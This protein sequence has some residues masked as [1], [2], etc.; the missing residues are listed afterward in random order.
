MADTMSAGFPKGGVSKALRTILCPDLTDH[1]VEA[2]IVR[3]MSHLL[4]EDRLNG[5][6]YRSRLKY[7][8]PEAEPELASKAKDALWDNI[9][10]SG[11]QI[12]EVASPIVFPDQIDFNRLGL[13][14]NRLL[15]HEQAG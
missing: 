4:V 7:R 15:S 12:R 5:L 13:A 14:A 1:D 6:L 3:L 9:V 10:K 8:P 2:I 11:W